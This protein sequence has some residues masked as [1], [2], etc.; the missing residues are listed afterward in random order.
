MR[1]FVVLFLFISLIFIPQAAFTERVNTIDEVMAPYDSENC[2]ECHE[3]IHENWAKSW[4]AKPITDPRSL[5]TFRTFILSGVDK[6]PEVKRTMLRDMCLMCH[7][8]A[9]FT[10]ASDELAEKI[11]GLVV[12]AADDKDAAKKDSAAK[13]LSKLN[14]NCLTCHGTKAPGGLPFGELEP[15][16][17]YGPGDAE[18]TPHGDFGYKTVKSESMKTSEFCMPCHHGCPPG[19]SSKECPTQWSV[20]Q[21]HYLAHGGD[22]TCQQ[23]HMQG[24]D[25][26]SHRFPGIYEKDFVKTGIEITIDA[27]PTKY[28]YHLE[29]RSV[30]GIFLNVHLRNT[31]AHDIPH[32]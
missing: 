18:D 26:E 19:M 22:K 23:C 15:N 1:L 24:E 3:E 13:E 14:M 16:T 20:Y 27:V 5:R 11:A 32:G 6:L 12:T 10:G 7:V 2:A 30:P 8:P 9:V 29:N 21:E 25:G 17:I 31:S 28:V 4:H